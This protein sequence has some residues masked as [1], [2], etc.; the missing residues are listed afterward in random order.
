[1]KFKIVPIKQYKATE[2]PPSFSIE[3]TPAQHVG[4]SFSSCTAGIA[5]AGERRMAEDTTKRVVIKQT[6]KP[7]GPSCPFGWSKPAV[8]V[9]KS[10]SVRWMRGVKSW[11]KNSHQRHQVAGSRRPF[12]RNE[13]LHNGSEWSNGSVSNMTEE[14]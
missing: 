12:A 14:L 7:I 5:R 10:E 4:G 1:M 9:W 13:I 2:H 6:S 11:L 8:M 3:G